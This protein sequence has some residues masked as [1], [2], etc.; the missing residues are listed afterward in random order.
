MKTK[1]YLTLIALV[2]M[3]FSTS[4]ILKAQDADQP[5]I[6]IVQTW[7]RNTGPDMNRQEADSLVR[8]Y[9]ENV[10]M[11]NE[12]V[13]SSRAMSHYFTADSREFVLI[14][15]YKSLTDMEAS[16]KI[17]EELENK[18]WPDKKSREP[19]DRLWMKHF[20][21]HADAIYG[22]INGTRK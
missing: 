3:T 2:A 18:L 20:G 4:V 1:N 12:K 8:H 15:E 21:H 14:N 22:E 11:K 7:I 13:I 6:F 17:D 16:F 19:Y 5:H 10:V 9:H